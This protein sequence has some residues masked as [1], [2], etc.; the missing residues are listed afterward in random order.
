MLNAAITFFVI[1]ILCFLLGL[2][3][4]AGLTM[5]IGKLLLG[6]FLVLGVL[7]LII[8]LIR[9]KNTPQIR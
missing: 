4:L 3:G 6:V 7:S 5:E 8:G 1:A 2:T 9:G